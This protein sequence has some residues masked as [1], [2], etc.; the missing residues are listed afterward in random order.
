MTSLKLNRAIFTDRLGRRLATMIVL[1]SSLF[2]L[3]STLIQ[4]GFDY[5]TDMHRIEGS[6]E[7]IES[8]YLQSITLSVWSLDNS[9]IDAQLEGLQQLADI[10]YVAIV[11]DGKILWQVGE[12]RSSNTLQQSYPLI[13]KA[14]NISD[15]QIGELV[16]VASVDKIYS[17]LIEKASII[18]VSNGIKTFMVSGF[19]M[20]LIW[21]TITRHLNGIA[22]YL[23]NL[24]LGRESLKLTLNKRRKSEW[25]D[26]IDMVADTINDMRGRIETSYLEIDQ[27]KDDL[28]KSLQERQ[29]LLEQEQRYKYQLEELVSE[30]TAE[31]EKSVE[32]LRQAQSL[33]IEH[34]KMAAL[35]GMVAG[36]AHEINTPIGVC[37]TASSFQSELIQSV[38]QQ[39][40]EGSLKRSDLERYLADLDQAAVLFQANI[41]KAADLI[42]NFK[43]IATDQSNDTLQRFNLKKYAVAT[44]QTVIPAYKHLGINIVLNISDSI[45]MESYPGSI[46]QVLTN[47]IS[48]SIIHGFTGQNGGTIRIAASLQ[49][50]LILIRY[51]DNGRGMTPKEQQKVFEPFYTSRRGLGGSGLGMSITYNIVKRILNG[52]IKVL[53]VKAFGCC[54][55]IQ[56]PL[57]M[58]DESAEISAE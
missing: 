31:L 13:Y 5:R 6:F 52:H 21:L 17:R 2:A 41:I 4:L 24:S 32:T 30:R 53:P 1:F 57:H 29:R 54:I 7:N 34:E 20:L 3:A 28:E 27:A 11:H 43:Q 42:A 22:Q 25:R 46:H 9:L 39:L 14:R 40:G 44:L 16:I 48:N 50:E 38:T 33:L 15:Q 37:L 55:E 51:Y 45:E 8:S 12:K 10:E 18:L 36:V 56:I 23:H 47:L 35:G 19:I 26:E 49:G 58:D